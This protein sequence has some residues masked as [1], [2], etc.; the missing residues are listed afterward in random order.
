MDLGY[1]VNMLNV[2]GASDE[3]CESLGYLCGYEA[4]LY[5]YF[6]NLVDKR[7]KILLNTFF[8]FSFKFSM[9]F[10]LIKRAL[11]FFALILCMLS[12]CQAWKPY[13]E[14]FE[15]LLLRVLTVY[16]LNSWV[17]KECWSS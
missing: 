3:A 14:E 10:A 12:Y 13:A 17:L 9:A 16:A 11:S 15:K 1:N 6:I 4:A 7:R 2:V 5:P 8:A